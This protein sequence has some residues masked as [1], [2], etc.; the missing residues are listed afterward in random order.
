[1][2]FNSDALFVLIPNQFQLSKPSGGRRRRYNQLV[3]MVAMDGIWFWLKE[4]VIVRAFHI[5]GE[6]TLG[7]LLCMWIFTLRIFTLKELLPLRLMVIYSERDQCLAEYFEGTL[8]NQF[9]VLTI[10]GRN[11]LALF[12]LRRE[13]VDARNGKEKFSNSKNKVS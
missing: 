5:H 3:M 8:Q 9:L 12:R 10:I 1:M 2:E 6:C 4:D 11:F 7:I 13:K